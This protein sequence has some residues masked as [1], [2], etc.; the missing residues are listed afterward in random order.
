MKLENKLGILLLLFFSFILFR[1]F[2]STALIVAND[3]P[4]LFKQ[5]R[6]FFPFWT[7]SWDYMGA[8]GIGASAI[9]TMWI[10]LYAN[11]VYFVSNLANIP[12]WLSQ[13]IFWIVP[14]LLISIL[15]SY[16]FSGLFVR[17]PIYRALSTIIYTFNTYI[18][19]IVGGGQFGI[20]F[21]YALSPLVLFWLFKLF[22]EANINSLLISS[23]L[24][25]IL[26]ALDPRVSFLTF[27]TAALWY[28]LLVRDFSPGKLK[29][30]FLNF[31]IAGILNSYWIIPA[32]LY[33]LTNTSPAVS[34]YFSLPGVRFLS[35]ATFENS[36]SFLHPNW[37]ENI[38]GKI[39]FQKPEFLLLPILAFGSMLFLKNSKSEIRNPKQIQNSKFKIL[40]NSTIE[41]SNNKSILFFVGLSLIGIFLGKGANEPFGQ[42][43][44]FLFQN[45]PG[46]NLF[47]DP[48]KFFILIALSYSLLI[49]FFLEQLSHRFEKYKYLVIILF[50]GYFLFLL[51]PAWSGELSG[52]FKP[53]DLPNDYVRFAN[54]LKEDREFGRTLW[55]PKRQKYG[56]FNPN[57]PAADSSVLFAKKSMDSLSRNEFS[58]LSI[59]YIIVP[60]DSDGEI[61][62]KDRK[63]DDKLRNRTIQRVEGIGLNNIVGFVNIAVYSVTDPKDHFW[64]PSSLG[65]N[66]QMINPAEYKVRVQNAEKG[67]ILVFSEGFD[68]NWTAVNLASQGDPLRAQKFG[69]NLNS[70][71]LPE[72]GDYELKIYYQPQQWVN[73][74]L[75][76]SGLTLSGLILWILVV[77]Y[78][79]GRAASRKY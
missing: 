13:R 19:L 73:I 63:Y 59:K 10:D 3:W 28:L 15:S 20:A 36:F 45:L 27:G 43:Y 4:L 1:F 38:F 33:L 62:L 40:N 74:G 16:K 14:Y 41:Q 5:S 21:S 44:L 9:K 64:S 50:V 57:H 75:I 52:I 60:T 26:I 70:F 34:N 32:F 65:I 69:N 48:T 68:K 29:Y 37:P 56:F 8:G 39:Y 66:Y 25:G 54:F 7:I 67:D 46:F 61:F 24:S 6:D 17:E 77:Y 51:R 31:I 30:I 78:R 79:H 71:I 23:L 47:R 2:F 58:E 35:F 18:L 53:K 42:V 55:V 12:W 76:I 49:P 11:F 72:N 22:K